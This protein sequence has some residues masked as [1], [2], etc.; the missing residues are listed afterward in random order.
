M[1]T[2]E[3]RKIFHSEYWARFKS[4]IA[5]TRS[6]QGRRIN[7][8][9]YP[10]RIKEIY[11]RLDV[12]QESA[13]FSIDIQSKD[14]GVRSIIWEQFTELKKVLENEIETPGTW[15]EEGYNKAGQ[16]ISSIYWRLEDVSIYNPKD[17]AKVFDF[18]K[19]KLVRFDRFYDI[20]K[21]ILFGLIK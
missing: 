16:K 17:E 2:K 3:E 20:Y 13:T 11:V 19:E 14:E 6:V 5:S 15:S 9:N 4:H 21:E 1:F 8:I 18:F 12:N 7:W 10:T